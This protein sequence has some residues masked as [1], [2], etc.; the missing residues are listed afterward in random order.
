MFMAILAP[1]APF[2]LLRTGR[3]DMYI[4]FFQAS[5]HNA[6][7]VFSGGESLNLRGWGDKNYQQIARGLQN[8]NGNG[9]G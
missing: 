8:K 7:M 3:L 2:F 5:W 1:C 4:F 6:V 9:V